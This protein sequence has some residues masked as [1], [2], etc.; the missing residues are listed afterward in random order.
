MEAVYWVVRSGQWHHAQFFKINMEYFFL[1]WIHIISSTILFGTGIG[2]AFFMFMANRKKDVREI[3][4]ATRIVVIADWIFTTPAVIIQLVSGLLLVE[5]Q[6]F[7][8]S[9]S[10]LWLA[11]AFYFFAV[12][13]WIPV[14]WWQIKMRDMAKL[15]IK[16]KTAL[17][18]LYWQINRYWII[19]GSLAFPAIIAVFY[20]MVFKPDF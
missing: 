6:G 11:I 16:N 7:L 17:P 14:V 20:L 8:F 4:F 5:N 12:F 2:S 19:L 10:W 13:C 1:K 3:Y 9:E 15:S 18:P